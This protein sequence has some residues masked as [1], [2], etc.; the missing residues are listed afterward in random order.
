LQHAQV[1]IKNNTL[2]ITADKMGL[3]SSTI[4]SALFQEARIRS[5]QT[6]PRRIRQI[7][8]LVLHYRLFTEVCSILQKTVNDELLIKN[9]IVVLKFFGRYLASFF[10]TV[11]RAKILMPHRVF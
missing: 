8:R 2:T 4:G 10:S 5:I 11:Q 9:R 7:I 1:E 3:I 6:V